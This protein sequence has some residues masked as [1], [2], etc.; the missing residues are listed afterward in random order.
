MTTDSVD[1]IGVGGGSPEGANSAY[2][3]DGRVVVDPGPPAES[4]WDD[5]R[6]GLERAGASID[7]VETVLVTHWHVDH[8]GLAP[9]LAEAAD[10]TLAMGAGDAPLVADYATA[11]ERRLER[12]REA[13]RRLGVPADVAEAV[14]AGD[15]PSPMPDS[16]PVERLA[17]G[18]RI[19]GLEVVATPGH[20]LGHTAFAGDG[21]LLVGDAVLPTYTPN[22]GG[23]DTR[24]LVDTDDAVDGSS[25]SA[26]IES[27]PLAAFLE[28]LDRLEDRPE[29]LLPGHG[30]AVSADRIA[31][32][33]G[34]HDER[35]RRVRE[36]L[37]GDG[38][39]SD[40]GGTSAASKRES[41][42]GTTP[43]ELALELFGD[44]EGVHVKF[45]VGEA[46]VHCRRLE[47]EGVLERVGSDPVEYR[48]S[49]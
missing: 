15:T 23:S 6:A 47:R 43:W 5:L 38:A 27:D 11:R 1:R 21:F 14:V 13:M 37:E 49:G 32:I 17:D 4:A 29:R 19:A 22:V 41:P 24:T 16:I 44:L 26:P 34:H 33:R 30:T 36:A 12:D 35:S 45:G 42:T 46:A 39:G 10:A 48:R 20:T 28:T 3:V 7:D 9:R 8:A 18:D 2:L 40:D 31:E 25:T